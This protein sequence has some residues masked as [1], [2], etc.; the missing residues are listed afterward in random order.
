VDWEDEAGTVYGGE[1]EVISGKL[2]STMGIADLG[3]LNW[4]YVS[5]YNGAFF[6]R[7]LVNVVAD[8]N[9]PI[10]DIYKA[11]QPTGSGVENTNFGIAINA[12]GNGGQIGG[13]FPYKAIVVTNRD[14]TDAATFKAAMAGHVVVYPLAQPVEY[15]LTANE[16]NTLY[17]ANNI[18]ASTGDT[19]VTYPCDTRLF[20]E[21]KIAEAVA[22]DMNS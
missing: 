3:D 19:E 2:K 9:T 6:S 14:Y 16:L 18:W 1:D 21:G 11:Y 10:S 5:Y 15:T 12:N 8:S 22:N 17:G 7:D 20:I 13:S 4:T